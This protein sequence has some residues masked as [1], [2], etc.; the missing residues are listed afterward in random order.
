MVDPVVYHSEI[1]TGVN[2]GNNFTYSLAGVLVSFT[3]EEKKIK[4]LINNQSSFKN[5]LGK[6]F[7]DL[8]S[9]PFYTLS[10]C[11]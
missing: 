11:L 10:D 1:R 9:S 3:E 2:G 5:E 8:K 4:D 7:D 6:L